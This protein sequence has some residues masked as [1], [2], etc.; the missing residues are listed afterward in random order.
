M[1]TITA[2]V[3]ATYGR[4]VFTGGPCV[5]K[6]TLIQILEE[7]GFPVV[8]EVA[9]DILVEGNPSLM[10]WIDRYAF[11]HEALKRQLRAEAEVRVA[12]NK[13][14][15]LDRGVLDGIA[16]DKVLGVPLPNFLSSL[17]NPGYDV[18][19]VFDELPTWE[20]NGVRYEEAG[21]A[22]LIT[23]VMEQVYEQEGCRIV[24]VP[25]ATPQR[26]I[27]FILDTVGWKAEEPLVALA[28]A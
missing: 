4:Y 27:D 9:T 2:C 15:F 5:G 11:Q 6:S 1:N 18:V 10:P 26:R 20:T 19:F 14:T 21:F 16:Y 28:A 25:F 13:P 17:R 12:G 23:P 3:S 22:R 7:R 24:R 8:R